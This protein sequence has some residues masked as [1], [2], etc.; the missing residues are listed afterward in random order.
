[1][2][3]RREATRHRSRAIRSAARHARAETV[4]ARIRGQELCGLRTI[5]GASDGD[6]PLVIEMIRQA[7]VC[8]ACIAFKVGIAR[9]RVEEVLREVR[10]TL[11]VTTRLSLCAGCLKYDT[12][13]RLA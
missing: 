3:E 5:S 1:M 2:R 13:Y 10:R 12:T 11:T 8:G 4:A 6:S 7:P 9:A